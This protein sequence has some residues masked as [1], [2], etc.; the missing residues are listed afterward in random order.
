MIV[1]NYVSVRFAHL[2]STIKVRGSSNRHNSHNPIIKYYPWTTEINGN[3]HE[4]YRP[5][6]RLSRK[7]ETTYWRAINMLIILPL[8]HRN[9]A[10][11]I[12]HRQKAPQPETVS[13]KQNNDKNITLVSLTQPNQNKQFSNK[14]IWFMMGL[15][16]FFLFSFCFTSMNQEV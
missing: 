12:S 16:S 9:Y 4:P 15:M 13:A 7:T 2:T 11:A 1:L 10:S 14:K 6:N 8:D 3:T 5:R